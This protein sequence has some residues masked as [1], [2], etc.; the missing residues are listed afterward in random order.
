MLFW[1]F[2]GPIFNFPSGMNPVRDEILRAESIRR[3]R[4]LRLLRQLDSLRA[5]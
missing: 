3:L 2:D 1:P 5:G 4:P